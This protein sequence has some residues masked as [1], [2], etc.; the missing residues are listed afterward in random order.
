MKVQII[1]NW[2]LVLFLLTY[3][4]N[5]DINEFIND[6]FVLFVLF[7]SLPLCVSLLLFRNITI[8]GFFIG[9]ILQWILFLNVNPYPIE[10]D[11]K[12]SIMSMIPDKYKPELQF[13]LKDINS[14]QIGYPIIIKPIYCS[15]DSKNITVIYSESEL[16][17]FIEKNNTEKLMVQTFLG[18]DYSVEIGVLFEKFQWQENGHIVEISEK[19]DSNSNLFDNRNYIDHS[20]K[21][22]DKITEIINNISK[23]VPNLNACRYDI[24]LKHIDDLEKDDFKILEINGTMGMSLLGYPRELGFLTELK[25]YINRVLI[26]AVNIVT[27]N[28]YSPITLPIVMFKSYYSKINCNDWENLYSLYS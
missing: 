26:G 20:T 2:V 7:T 5:I 24:L 3:Y 10:N 18:N 8:F 23:T 22:N 11:N 19:I 28:G 4:I 21:I 13:L 15:G 14:Q 6:Q 12:M 27:F 25:W 1:S 16:N 17:R 9:F